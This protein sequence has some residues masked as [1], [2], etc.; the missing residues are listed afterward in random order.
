MKCFGSG[1]IVMLRTQMTTVFY[2]FNIPEPNAVASLI[3]SNDSDSDSGSTIWA[4]SRNIAG[5]IQQSSWHSHV[6]F[7]MIPFNVKKIH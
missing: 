5:R 2:S 1:N 6:F 7:L 3:H 4:Q